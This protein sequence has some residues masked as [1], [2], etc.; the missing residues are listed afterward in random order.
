MVLFG[1]M[2][3]NSHSLLH[4]TAVDEEVKAKKPKLVV[5]KSK[6]HKIGF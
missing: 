2:K 4:I 6:L 1:A 3:V 5:S